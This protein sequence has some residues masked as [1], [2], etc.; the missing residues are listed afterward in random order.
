MSAELKKLAQDL[1]LKG[2]TKAALHLQEDAI[3]FANN[4]LLPDS[5]EVVDTEITHCYWHF[6][7]LIYHVL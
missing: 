5:L 4:G 3:N 7:I 6:Q 2:F 1:A